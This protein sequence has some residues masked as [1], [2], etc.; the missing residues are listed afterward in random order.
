MEKLPFYSPELQRSH[1]P[2]ARESY[3]EVVAIL[4]DV[5]VQ[6][7]IEAGN[8][9]LAMIRPNVGPNA[10]IEGLPDLEASDRIEEMIEGLGVM[11][12]F[13]FRFSAEAAEEFYG[14]GPKQSMINERPLDPNKY[15][16]RWPEFIAFMA[17]GNTTVLLLHSP[18]GDAIA[19]WRSHLGH[20]NIDEVRDASTIRGKFGV[21]KF[22]NLVHGSDSPEAVRREL[23]IIKD[24]LFTQN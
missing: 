19:K 7:E 1:D 15:S 12:K 5:E 23:K 2:I 8:V 4:Q 9:T 18:D 11:A 20:W 16:S 10:N 24:C 14:G 21:N 6:A 13:S 17:S 3:G 22:N